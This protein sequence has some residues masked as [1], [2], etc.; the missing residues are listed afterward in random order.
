M[1]LIGMRDNGEGIRTEVGKR[2]WVQVGQT[3]FEVAGVDPKEQH[4]KNLDAC[5]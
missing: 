2:P 1:P 4:K 3:E 5:A